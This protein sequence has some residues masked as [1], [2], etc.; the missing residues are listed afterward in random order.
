M[1]LTA[2][3]TAS[4]TFGRVAGARL[5]H[6]SF[7]HSSNE[8]SRVRCSSARFIVASNAAIIARE[9]GIPAV[10]GVG[11]ATSLPD[12]VRDVITTSDE[13][14]TPTRPTVLGFAAG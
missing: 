10:R 13:M 12:A 7:W 9:Y 5:S 3:W 2:W 8:A 11:Q 14:P 6:G 4:R 1:T